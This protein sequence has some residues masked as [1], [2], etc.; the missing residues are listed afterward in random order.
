MTRLNYYC[1]LV[2][3]YDLVSW[4]KFCQSQKYSSWINHSCYFVPWLQMSKEFLTKNICHIVSFRRRETY[5]FQTQLHL[6]EGKYDVIWAAARQNQQNVPSK[7]SVHPVWS[8]SS[9]ST[10]RS[11]GSLAILKAHSKDSDRTGWMP[12]LIFLHWAHSHF[13][14]FVMRW[15][16]YIYCG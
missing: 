14:G 6:K 11:F 8:K 5:I 10:W 7:D 13:V 4:Y 9:L 2:S 12:R 16:N 1:S 3:L 15:L